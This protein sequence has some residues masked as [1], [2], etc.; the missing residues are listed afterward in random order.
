[1]SAPPRGYHELEIEEEF[2]G[3]PLSILLVEYLGNQSSDDESL[4]IRDDCEGFLVG[5]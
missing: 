3:A 2:V 5:N 1:M 4:C